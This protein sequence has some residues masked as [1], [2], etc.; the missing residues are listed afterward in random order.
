[1]VL[2]V[3]VMV[4]PRV[5]GGTGPWSDAPR[6]EGGLSPRVRGNHTA[7]GQTAAAGRVYPR[8]CGGT[9][10]Y[11][12]EPHWTPGL[13]PRVRGNQ[14]QGW[15]EFFRHRSIPA[16]AGE[17]CSAMRCWSWWS[18]YPRVCGGTAVGTF[19]STYIAGLSPR[20]RGNQVIRPFDF[21]SRRSIPACAG[22]PSGRWPTLLPRPV[23]PR[24]CGGT[25]FKNPMAKTLAGLSPRV[26]GN[27]QCDFVKDGK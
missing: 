1:M 7:T 5:C 12:T 23:Y 13:S 26:R 19:T 10:C 17:P 15:R 6:T 14:R 25:I 2:A 27:R 21:H 11:L 3:A 20:V 18:V 16:C 4:Y 24:V 9:V 8:V 22:E